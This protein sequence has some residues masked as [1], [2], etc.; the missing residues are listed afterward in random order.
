MNLKKITLNPVNNRFLPIP[1]SASKLYEPE[2]KITDFEFIKELGTGSFGRVFL[3]SHKKTK[4]KYAIKSIDKKNKSNIEEKP[5]FR[6]EIE[7]MYRINHP[8]V[9]KLYGHFEDNNFCYFIM[10]YVPNGNVYSLIPKHGKKKQSNQLIASIVKDIISATYYLHHMNPPIIHRDIKPENVLIDENSKAILTDFGWSNYLNDSNKRRTVCGTPIY[11]APE[12]IN[13][14][15]HD[16]R[17]DIWCIGV[18]LFELVTGRVPF[19]GNDIHT[20]KNN[21][22]LMNIS[23]PSDINYEA[24]DL[25][26]KILKYNPNDRLTITEILNHSF[27]KKYYPNAVNELIVPEETLKFKTFI[28]SVDNPKNW[29]PIIKTEEKPNN[30]SEKKKYPSNNKNNNNQIISFP[31]NN[32]NRLIKTHANGYYKINTN[33]VAKCK[34]EKK[35][36]SIDKE[37]NFYTINTDN[38]IFHKYNKQNIHPKTSNNNKY[39][40]N[41]SYNNIN[42]FITYTNY[43]DKYNNTEM[44]INCDKINNAERIVNYDKMNNTEKHVDYNK[45]NKNTERHIDCDKINKYDLLL[46]KYDNLKKDYYLL[47]KNHGEELDKLRKELKDIESKLSQFIKDGKLYDFSEKEYRK[48]KKE[49]KDLEIIYEDLKNE[50]QGLKE[51][52]K[53]YSEYI[54]DQKEVYLDENLNEVRNSIKGKNKNN[55]TKAMDKLKYDLDEKTQKNFYAIIKEKE[56]QFEK[57]KEDEKKRRIKEKEKFSVLINKYD[58]TLSWQEQENKDLKIRLQELETQFV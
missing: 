17:V 16:G 55:F 32:N 38:D 39:E 28:V 29:N 35:N 33:T 5:Y 10:E 45:I 43:F 57:I 44:Y 23:W 12:M 3:A 21:I 18:L 48:K 14:L 22:R 26:S 53:Y 25:I 19:L 34:L 9:V 11:L 37:N 31:L 58:K 47:K 41:Y 52:I 13:K 46:K 49:I 51:R 2:P 6:R 7:I 20:L 27:I 15:G 56:K 36:T 4:V 30:N 8:N 1:E 42:N 24:K 40:N 54:K 50:N